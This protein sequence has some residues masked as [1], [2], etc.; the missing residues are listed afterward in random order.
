[1]ATPTF[2]K[3]S[4]APGTA[5]EALARLE[6]RAFALCGL[7]YQRFAALSPDTDP[8]DAAY[9]G[10]Y[11]LA[12]D[13]V[14]CRSRQE[15]LALAKGWTAWGVSLVARQIP[16]NVDL[17]LFASEKDSIGVAASVDASLVYFETPGIEQGAPLRKLL[18]A[19]VA[20]FGC[21]VCG[22]GADRAYSVGY[23]P[24]DPGTIVARLER[25]DLFKIPTPN[26]HAISVDLVPIEK[27]NQL[28]AEPTL[29]KSKFF[30]YGL[31]TSGHHLLWNLA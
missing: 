5:E 18:G 16:G 9:T 20:G 14:P 12:G 2:V 24:L 19:L 30:R 23:V 29:P 13:M 3:F 21:Q 25:G 26:F 8:R 10:G 6:A 22:F 17:Y 11:D 7:E 31:A 28:L 15:A 4:R 27:M 1:M